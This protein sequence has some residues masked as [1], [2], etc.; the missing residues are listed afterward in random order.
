MDRHKRAQLA[1]ELAT[2]KKAKGDSTHGSCSKM[3]NMDVNED[4]ANNAKQQKAAR[5]PQDVTE[6]G[7]MTNE[8]Y[9]FGVL[10]LLKVSRTIGD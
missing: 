5:K 3:E 4:A 6:C 2:K 8:P 7:M 9:F 1:A 10:T